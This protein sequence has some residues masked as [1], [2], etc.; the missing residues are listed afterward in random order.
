MRFPTAMAPHLQKPG[1]IF[2]TL[3]PNGYPPG[4]L[5]LCAAPYLLE[6]RNGDRV[7]THE[8]REDAV[9]TVPLADD[10][11]GRRGGIHKSLLQKYLLQSV[12]LRQFRGR[13]IRANKC[14][15]FRVRVFSNGFYVTTPLCHTE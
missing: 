12:V 4:S 5:R 2:R 9:Y 11:K 8:L 6:V 14:L 10:T 3:Q 1:F 13:E 15:V 7:E